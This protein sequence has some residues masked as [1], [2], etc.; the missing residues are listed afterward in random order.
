MRCNRFNDLLGAALRF[1]VDPGQAKLPPEPSHLPLG[2]LAGA[3]LNQ[4]NRVRERALAAQV[5]NNL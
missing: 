2:E 1:E 3:D 4:R 5:L